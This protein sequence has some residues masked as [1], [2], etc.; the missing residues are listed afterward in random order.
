MISS[1]KLSRE[2]FDKKSKLENIMEYFECPV[3]FNTRQ[4]I[5]ECVSCKAR[6]CCTCLEDFSK[7]EFQKN[8]KFK[9]EK[10]FRCTICLK[11]DVQKP[12]HRFLYNLL[13]DL[14]FKCSSCHRTMTYSVIKGHKLRKECFPMADNEEEM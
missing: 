7:A 2:M 12:M 9:Q 1:T 8:P 6:S 5:F 3:C 11:V 4:E 14:K 10:R 13:Q